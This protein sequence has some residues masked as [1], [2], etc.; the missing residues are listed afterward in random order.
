M[1]TR[2]ALQLFACA[3]VGLA[4]SA[5]GCDDGGDEA[6][7]DGNGDSGD[8]GEGAGTAGM[9]DTGGRG[10][11]ASGTGGDAGD[12]G[13][14][15]GSSTGGTGESGAGGTTAG[16][17][18]SG[19]SATGGSGTGGS[20]QGPDCPTASPE[21]AASC[22]AVG[23]LCQYGPVQCRCGENSAWSCQTTECPTVL[24]ADASSC[25]SVDVIQCRYGMTLCTCMGQWTC[26]LCP[27][28]PPESGTSCPDPTATCRYPPEVCFCRPAGWAC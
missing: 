4:A 7:S 19:G 11:S 6:T 5:W 24:P 1:A 26:D 13:G 23:T 22:D 9:G 14:S 8:A 27:P 20:G 17:S 28:S 12:N 10:G 18:P 2:N 21:D 3:L 25:A 15:S 16:G